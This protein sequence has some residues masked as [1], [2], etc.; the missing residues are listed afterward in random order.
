[1]TNS[2]LQLGNWESPMAVGW[3]PRYF[4]VNELIRLL[5]LSRLSTVLQGIWV[6]PV[7][8]LTKSGLSNS[9]QNS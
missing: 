9:T 6:D 4:G 3:L 8:V 7:M 2:K 1:M 5:A